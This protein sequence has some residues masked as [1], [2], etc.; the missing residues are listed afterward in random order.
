MICGDALFCSHLLPVATHVCK[1]FKTIK[2]G[3]IYWTTT[4]FYIP[5]SPPMKITYFLLSRYARIYHSSNFFLLYFWLFCLYFTSVV[6][7]D[8]AGPE[9]FCKLGT[10]SVINS[11]SDSG[12]GSG[13]ESG[14]KLSS[15]STNKYKVKMYRWYAVKMNFSKQSGF[16]AMFGWSEFLMYFS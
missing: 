4:I 12:S 16:V 14:S 9:I 11:G 15:V 8:S 3:S 13:F 7:P 2:Q 10:G 5:P 6:H 1:S